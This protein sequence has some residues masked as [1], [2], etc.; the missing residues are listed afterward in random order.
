MRIIKHATLVTYWRK[1]AETEQPL[2]AWYQAVKSADWATMNE[3]QLAFPKAR[4][5][6]ADRVRFEIHGGNYRLIAA[7]FFPGN[8]VWI[9]FIGTHAE[10]NRIDA[11]TVDQ[12]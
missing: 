11:L 8:A 10:Y 12:F 2:K 5:L 7:F 4:V 6:N 3:V 1:H 9:K